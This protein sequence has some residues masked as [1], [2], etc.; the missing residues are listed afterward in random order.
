MYVHATVIIINCNNTFCYYNILTICNFI[1]LLL[2]VSNIIHVCMYVFA[3]VRQLFYLSLDALSLLLQRLLIVVAAIK[4]YCKHIKFNGQ[5]PVTHIHIC[6]YVFYK[7]VC[8]Q[9]VLVCV[10]VFIHICCQK[11]IF[12]HIYMQVYNYLLLFF[13]LYSDYSAQRLVA[14][15]I[16][17]LNCCFYY[18][19]FLLLC[20]LLTYISLRYFL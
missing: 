12:V 1:Q 10:C 15:V 7:Y 2:Q 13:L 17:R 6:I 5:S 11:A 20:C 8:F 19:N 3:F 9:A 16:A 4:L 14:C 18:I